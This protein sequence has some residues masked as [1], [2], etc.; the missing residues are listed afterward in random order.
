MRYVDELWKEEN[1]KAVYWDSYL[2]ALACSMCGTQLIPAAGS[3][4]FPCSKCSLG[5]SK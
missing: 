1:T 4:W 5:G 3:E 2:N